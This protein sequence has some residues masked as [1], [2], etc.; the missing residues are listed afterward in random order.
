[1]ILNSKLHFKLILLCIGTTI[2]LSHI[3]N[4]QISISTLL[5]NLNDFHSKVCFSLEHHR[6]T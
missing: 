3:I 4:N 5:L 1:M 6:S 2:I